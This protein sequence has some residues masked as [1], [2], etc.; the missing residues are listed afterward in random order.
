MQLSARKPAE[1]SSA[2]L[3]KDDANHPA[4]SDAMDAKVD[5]R[6]NCTDHRESAGSSP[7]IVT[8]S[9]NAQVAAEL[10]VPFVQLN[11]RSRPKAPTIASTAE[12]E[13]LVKAVHQQMVAATNRYAQ[14]LQQSSSGAREPLW[15]ASVSQ[16][17]GPS[18]V[19]QVTMISS[20][21]NSA[22]TPS[23][24]E[25][26]DQPVGFHRAL[27]VSGLPSES[28]TDDP[29]AGHE[30]LAPH[31]QSQ[32]MKLPLQSQITHLAPKS[33]VP[34]IGE[35]PLAPSNTE[36]LQ[37]TEA[38]QV[39]SSSSVVVSSP[40]SWMATL[41]AC[42]DARLNTLVADDK[43]QYQANSVVHSLMSLLDR[44]RAVELSRGS[45][46]LAPTHL[47]SVVIE[48]PNC[49]QQKSSAET[50][51]L[52]FH[53]KINSLLL[54]REQ[55][56]A[57][58]KIQASVRG[59]LTR[60]NLNKKESKT[61]GARKS[62]QLYKET[63][64]K[65]KAVDL[66][67]GDSTPEW[68]KPKAVRPCPN[69]IL[70]AA[71]KQYA[72]LQQLGLVDGPPINLPGNRKPPTESLMH[73]S[74]DIALQTEMPASINSFVRHT[75]TTA[76]LSPEKNSSSHIL[77]TGKLQDELDHGTFNGSNNSSKAESSSTIVSTTGDSVAV[78]TKL[79]SQS[80]KPAS[81]SV[82]ILCGKKRTPQSSSPELDSGGN[83]LSLVAPKVTLVRRRKLND[84]HNVSASKS[85]GMLEVLPGDRKESPIIPLHASSSETYDSHTKF[86]LERRKPRHRVHCKPSSIRSQ[87][88]ALLEAGDM[89][90]SRAVVDHGGGSL[91]PAPPATH[92]DV[93][94]PADQQPDKS[95]LS[96]RIMELRAMCSQFNQSLEA[97]RQ[98][99]DQR[100]RCNKAELEKVA[101]QMAENARLAVEE[102]LANHRSRE[103]SVSREPQVLPGG[104]SGG[105][106]A[107]DVTS[108]FEGI[109][110]DVEDVQ[111]TV[112]ET[113]LDS[114]R[115]A[116][117]RSA[118]PASMQ[119][120]E[121]LELN[122][123]QAL[124]Q[125]VS[126]MPEQN[127]S[128]R[129]QKQALAIAACHMYE[130]LIKDEEN[131]CKQHEEL[132]R[133][134]LDVVSHSSKSHL[135]WLLL[136]KQEYVMAG[137]MDK[138]H[139]VKKKQRA[140]I[141]KY[142]EDKQD[143]LKSLKL[144]KQTSKERI[145]SLKKQRKTFTEIVRRLLNSSQNSN[146]PE[147][148]VPSR[149][150]S[151]G[152]VDSKEQF[153]GASSQENTSEIF[154][155]IFYDGSMPDE[156]SEPEAASSTKPS[157][158]S[159][160]KEATSI[161]SV[162]VSSKV[163]SI[164]GL[165]SV[166]ELAPSSSAVSLKGGRGRCMTSRMR[167]V[168]PKDS[169]SSIYTVMDGSVAS[170][171][172]DESR[173]NYLRSG[174]VQMIE[175]TLGKDSKN[176]ETT[177]KNLIKNAGGKN[178]V[179]YYEKSSNYVFREVHTQ[180]SKT[181]IKSSTSVRDVST[182]PVNVVEEENV[183]PRTSPIGEEPDAGVD[184]RSSSSLPESARPSTVSEDCSN[185][186]QSSSKST[187][188]PE[189]VEEQSSVVSRS[190]SFSSLP[191]QASGPSEKC[192]RRL[193]L[194]LKMPLSLPPSRRHKRR[195][196]SGS[197][198][199]FIYSQ[200]ETLSEQSDVEGR[201][202]A[203]QEQLDRRKQE[204]EKLHRE[205]KRNRREKLKAKEESLQK[206]ILAYEK[207][208]QETKHNLEQD[209]NSSSSMVI[210]RPKI[211]Q[212]RV[213]ERKQTAK[214][215]ATVSSVG[216]DCSSKTVR[217]TEIVLSV[218]S[219]E[220]EQ[221]LSVLS[222]HSI[223]SVSDLESVASVPSTAQ[224]SVPE[225]I[226][227]S[228]GNEA[229]VSNAVSEEDQSREMSFISERENGSHNS[230]HGSSSPKSVSQELSIP[231]AIQSPVKLRESYDDHVSVVEE[232]CSDNSNKNI[233]SKEIEEILS[234][235]NEFANERASCDRYSD[236]F[237]AGSVTS[238]LAQET[239]QS[240]EDLE[241]KEENEASQLSSESK[242][243]EQTHDSTREEHFSDVKG[244]YKDVNEN[245]SELEVVDGRSIPEELDQT[246]VITVDS[247]KTESDLNVIVD[248]VKHNIFK[249]E[250]EEKL[251]VK[252]VDMLATEEHLQK[253]SDNDIGEEQVYDT[254]K[255]RSVQVTDITNV[256][257]ACEVELTDNL[258][259]S[260]NQ[261]AEA[262]SSSD[263]DSEIDVCFFEEPGKE[264]N[265]K[266]FTDSHKQL[267][268]SKVLPISPDKI[269][270]VEGITDLIMQQVLSEPLS[271]IKNCGT[272]ST[273]Q[274]IADA[275]STVNTATQE[276]DISPKYNMMV[277]KLE[278]ENVQ[279]GEDVV[280]GSF[281]ASFIPAD[282]FSF[283]EQSFLNADIFPLV[284]VRQ[285]EK[286]AINLERGDRITDY[287]LEESLKHA[288]RE[289][290]KT[291]G[292]KR[293]ILTEVVTLPRSS[294]V[295]VRK[296]VGE[297]MMEAKLS[298]SVVRDKSRVQ[299]LMVT[300]YDLLSPTDMLDS[301]Q[302]S[303]VDSPDCTLLPGADSPLND[304]SSTEVTGD[305]DTR[306]KYLNEVGV[307]TDLSKVAP[308]ECENEWFDED[309][310]LSCRREAEELR[311]RQLRIDR[312]IQ[313]LEQA[314]EQCPYF[315]IREIPN[316][317]PP[318]YTPPTPTSRAQ[319]PPSPPGQEEVCG[320]VSCV[321]EAAYDAWQAGG[322][323]DALPVPPALQGKAAFGRFLFQL[324]CQLVRDAC[325]RDEGP[326]PP[327]EWVPRAGRPP[328]HSR[329]AV[330][331]L[332]RR[333]LATV[334]R[335]V[336][337][338]GP[339]GDAVVRWGRRKRDLVDEL[340]VRE[341]RKEEAGW[342]R[343]DEDEVAVKN[344][345][346][347][348]FLVSL[349]DDAVSVLR[350]VVAGRNTASLS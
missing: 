342:T 177:T 180:T 22:R 164:A 144:Q 234:L 92:K 228:S 14:N 31:L 174:P 240:V 236:D 161:T 55:E 197:D 49:I 128:S 100:V 25:V 224:E 191:L 284:T 140:V 277:S 247:S 267:T 259:M 266:E 223:V 295:D 113:L 101:A 203:L 309:Y 53:R 18:S 187:Q 324:G 41:S 39:P 70:S 330:L 323:P 185:Y 24:F 218:S 112:A 90:L 251:I 12:L 64:E 73:P 121:N 329:R 179:L 104:V 292:E 206:Q 211:K 77:Y 182:S 339:D 71:M 210:M 148:E 332:V 119:L 120:S 125:S 63:D 189:H 135:Q 143:I 350:R 74:R 283:K 265:S 305:Q 269:S 29:S 226:A 83:S 207:F 209:L 118:A 278:Q 115:D 243:G 52:E 176:V 230:S 38:P 95:G 103:P 6:D 334:F 42:A 217:S 204:A 254:N 98:T 200:N 216:L 328:P 198:E 318:P 153:K 308:A 248:E 37:I 169:F 82:K 221:V 337:R 141:V 51:G 88:S 192:G 213:A 232:I 241:A 286:E 9:Q 65:R 7:E 322:D 271:N 264:I 250:V 137:K 158:S 108:A 97:S 193:E 345:L 136:K 175:L 296:R 167:E 252:D 188:T 346:T 4:G 80:Q 62:F 57:A 163:S 16:V 273:S 312:E 171:A 320:V 347:D 331:E 168:T 165:E 280:D 245:L 297:I 10:H 138:L 149:N 287:L 67:S 114:S 107:F 340:L 256:I 146:G 348:V 315:Y 238:D 219:S 325:H 26:T 275:S 327:W 172:R 145:A 321:A 130:E 47:G 160:L 8:S 333:E 142:Y 72:K 336:P 293:Q 170:S 155:E 150:M 133:K 263:L 215:H 344:K 349:L 253:V 199:S 139:S 59:Y 11:T 289:V 184:H 27:Q 23:V 110:R 79:S 124:E 196:S 46:K 288:A 270:L 87:S 194:G 15:S 122:L 338:S 190:R 244:K 159:A 166:S 151:S 181:S 93:R 201:I 60:K 69:N 225:E 50:S 81:P 299:D 89:V 61:V 242:Y 111:I 343:Y 58:I 307:G 257:S 116:S 106:S 84:V 134:K 311:R 294:S 1:M 246:I 35:S 56:K 34:H 285:R 313:E 229:S 44:K 260:D 274:P 32:L 300:T 310:G 306:A 156:K 261:I 13:Q 262:R 91:L 183:S 195:H 5:I 85:E 303:P 17:A 109:E 239:S 173:V 21:H 19:S 268:E 319:E 178:N 30:Y 76:R 231:T 282:E 341:G 316:K 302:P 202:T 123:S 227:N 86:G 99:F 96:E 43:L 129:S 68:L 154:E 131:R 222:N 279:S 314:Q 162:G 272:T 78:S 291:C 214:P 301:A 132:I 36:P 208:I 147:N 75:K 105:M 2:L 20:V 281:E 255:D 276:G 237:E 45:I 66:Q 186:N 326:R 335:S 205:Q 54:S 94:I 304:W 235:R 258:L 28:H 126:S 298:P 152:S 249:E 40:T 220:A 48:Q 33:R 102:F 212:P 233:C 3:V 117:L 290:V 157:K 127:S 317:P